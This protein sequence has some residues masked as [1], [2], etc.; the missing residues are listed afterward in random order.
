[1]R[2]LIVAMALL[3]ACSSKSSKSEPQAGVRLVYQID[4]ADDDRS[5]DAI[6]DAA[7]R[8][9]EV[10][11][12]RVDALDIDRPAVFRKVDRI[13]IELPGAS[14]R[15]LT[16]LRASLDRRGRLEL[17]RLDPSSDEMRRLWERA[18]EDPAARAAGI[19]AEVDVWNRPDGAAM[20][21]RYLAGPTDAALRTYLAGLS[22]DLPADR[23]ILLERVDPTSPGGPSH[24]RTYLAGERAGIDGHIRDARVATDPQLGQ[25]IVDVTLDDIGRDRF[26]DLTRRALG[27]KLG[28]VI[29][30][31]ILSAPIVQT[32]IPGGRI[33]ITL[34]TGEPA[35][36]MT[37]AQSLA[38]ALR[39][40]SLPVT[41]HLMSADRFGDGHN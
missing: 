11:R 21:E 20:R 1:M 39:T 27:E 6:D 38:A 37:E 30:G 3:C 14:D 22:P 19:R 31:T 7:D 5:I 28:I 12:N 35:S 34:G 17:R 16:W 8:A 4:V 2:L 24:W 9:L 10:I 33:Q 15:Q 40:S 18:A 41:L 36:L 13:V 26:A 25:P 23:E 29:D 32:E